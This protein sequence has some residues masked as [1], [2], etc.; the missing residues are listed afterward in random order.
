MNPR[1]EALYQLGLLLQEQNYQ[2]VTGTPETHRRVNAR[3]ENRLGRTREEIFGWSRPF[4]E[5]APEY[6]ELLERAAQLDRSTSGLARSRV[7]FSTC[8]GKLY[9][10]SSYPTLGADSVFFGPDTYRFVRWLKSTAGNY[11]RGVDLGCGSGAGGIS[12]SD[13]VDQMIL[14]DINPLAL[15]FAAINA[16]LAKSANTVLADSNLLAGITGAIDLVVANPPYLADDEHRLYRD[17]GGDFG[18]ELS[19]KIVEESL[20]RLSPGGALFLYTGTPVVNGV[21][22]FLERAASALRRAASWA[23]EELDPDVFGEELDRPQYRT[24]SR[25]AVLGL[26]AQR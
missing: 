20:A 15:R 13:R 2:F 22:V 26:R 7:R 18:C 21:Y 12:L 5:L 4:L 10:H 1:D 25:I 3:T 19:V 17:G 23:W 11:L 9:V 6:L 8:D 24:A 14:G 16:R